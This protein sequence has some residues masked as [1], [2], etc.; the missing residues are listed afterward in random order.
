MTYSFLCTDCL[1]EVTEEKTKAIPRRH[2]DGC[3]KLC[4]YAPGGP[5][6]RA[7]LVATASPDVAHN[8]TIN[9]SGVADAESLR[10]AMP[11]LMAQAFAEAGLT[12]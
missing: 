3:G 11:E 2:C 9:I 10:K 1:P 4:T 7:H 6:P 12:T 8:I 5:L